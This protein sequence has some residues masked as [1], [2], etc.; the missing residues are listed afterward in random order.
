MKPKRVQCDRC[1][2]KYRLRTLRCPGCDA[3]NPHAAGK[4]LTKSDRVVGV[5]LLVFGILSGIVLT[6]LLI[7]SVWIG[8]M[9]GI[10]G[11]AACIILMVL[12][13]GLIFHGILLL[14]GIHPRD[15]YSW[16][17][18][19]PSVARRL[20]WGLLALVIVIFF[21]VFFFGEAF[22]TRTVSFD[23]D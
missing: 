20:A 14:I 1:G 8:A 6:V 7:A 23:D 9:R 15:F 17:D 22:P 18:H 2:T 5:I 12:P 4:G 16:W 21:I 3:L 10:R 19:L 13:V 11:A